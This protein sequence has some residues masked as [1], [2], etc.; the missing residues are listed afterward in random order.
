VEASIRANGG[1]NDVTTIRMWA[2]FGNASYQQGSWG[3]FSPCTSGSA[4]TTSMINAPPCHQF[5]SVDPQGQIVEISASASYMLSQCA[6]PFAAPGHFRGLTL[7]RLFQRIFEAKP[8]H[9]FLSSFNEHIGGRQ[10]PAS[11]ANT[12][13]CQG[14]P[15]DPDNNAVWVDSYASE[16]SRDFEPSVEVGDHLLQ[17]VASCVNLY[18]QGRDCGTNASSLC[19][20]TADKAVFANIWSLRL[21]LVGDQLLT[22]SQAERA[23]LL[24]QGWQEVCTPFQDPSDF[25]VDSSLKEGRYGPFILYNTSS[26]APSQALYRC[27]NADARHHLMSTAPDCEGLGNPESILGYIATARG[28]EMLRGL[29]RC[30]T[31]SGGYTHALDLPCDPG[32]ANSTVE[33]GFVR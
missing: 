32:M 2:L 22:A 31:P 13:F 33:L 27:Y 11:G 4:Y 1:R 24:A 18:K 23:A 15:N 10:A 9:I 30:R 25:C 12:A 28:K 5:A 26:A 3:F 19:C 29:W 8:A 7:Q 17:V 16:F 20:T 14:L 21:P 6:L